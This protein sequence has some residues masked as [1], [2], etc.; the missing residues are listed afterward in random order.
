MIHRIAVSSL[1]LVGL[2]LLSG[3]ATPLEQCLR[4]A[5]RDVLEIQRELDIRRGNVQRGTRI[6][7]VIMP[8]LQMSFCAGPGGQPVPCQRWVQETQ[9]FHHPINRELERER[10]ALLER[11]MVRAEAA[12]A[13]ASAQCRAAYP[14]E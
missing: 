13:Q 10:I 12:A 4:Q 8:E 7:R 14:P 11:Q 3:C 5:N 2:V 6:E 1:A 9:E